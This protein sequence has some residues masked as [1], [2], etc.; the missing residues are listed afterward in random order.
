MRI[1]GFFPGERGAKSPSHGF[2]LIEI[3]LSCLLVGVGLSAA[4]GVVFAAVVRAR[5]ASFWYTT[6][7]TAQSALD[8]AVAVNVITQGNAAT[9]TPIDGFRTEY[10]IRIDDVLPTGIDP[11]AA[12]KSYA[13]GVVKTFRVRVY[14]TDEDM[15]RE[16]R[17]RAS[18]LF[19]RYLRN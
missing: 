13:G 1:S 19:V 9:T 18:Y 4:L 2:T 7:P 6:A 11:L 8:Y 15:T 16:T 3:L 10:A 5:Q 14:D 17:E 12:A